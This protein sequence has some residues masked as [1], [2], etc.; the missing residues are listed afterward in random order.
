[1]GERALRCARTN[2][3]FCNNFPCRASVKRTQPCPESRSRKWSRVVEARGGYG[4]ETALGTDTGLHRD[5]WL[6]FV[7]CRRDRASGLNCRWNVTAYRLPT[8]PP[9]VSLRESFLSLDHGTTAQSHCSSLVSTCPANLLHPRKA[10]QTHLLT[11]HSPKLV[12]ERK[13][14]YLE[15]PPSVAHRPAARKRRA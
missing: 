10:A 15:E 11:P 9:H 2:P 14:K 7:T 5:A 6:I 4:I 8:S 3:R 1:M 12:R 13:R